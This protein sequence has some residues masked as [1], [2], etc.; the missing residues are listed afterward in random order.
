MRLRIHHRTAYRYSTAVEESY[1]EARLQPTSDGRQSCESFELCLTPSVPV[2]RYQ[3]LHRNLVDHF[4]LAEPHLSLE[5]DAR[6]IVT[7]VPGPAGPFQG[8]TK[9][10]LGECQ[11]ME[12]CYDFLQR[13]EYV[14]LEVGVWRVA[15]DYTADR[16]DV[17]D[18]VV[19]IR[20]GIYR[21][22]QYDPLATTVQTS[23]SEALETRRGVCQD[24]AHV[25]IGLCRSVRIPARY[26]SGYLYV[27]QGETLR[28]NL[29]SH[30][31]VEVFLPGQGWI[32]VDPTNRCLA[33]EHHVK[34]AVGR[35]YADAAPLVGNF[36]GQAAQELKVDLTIDRLPD[37][38]AVT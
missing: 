24:F 29:A 33:D 36:R 5:I 10:R 35:D 18:M 7:T 25:M 21:D 31:W 9:S 4:Y 34:V 11:R 23:M 2:R 3:D 38:P 8:F 17:W 15:Q 37:P 16:E 13:S 1:N 12:R 27:A 19:G 6:S 28:G 14:S 20:D 30:A 26:V 32:G 22:F